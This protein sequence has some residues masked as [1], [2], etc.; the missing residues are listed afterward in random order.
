MKSSTQLINNAIVLIEDQLDAI[1]KKGAQNRNGIPKMA[2]FARDVL[3]ESTNSDMNVLNTMAT[4]VAREDSRR[5]A[6]LAGVNWDKANLPTD[7]RAELDG[8]V[9]GLGVA[10]W[11]QSVMDGICWSVRRALNN[12]DYDEKTAGEIDFASGDGMSQQDDGVDDIAPNVEQAYAMLRNLQ[13]WLVGNTS[14]ITVE[15]LCVFAVRKPQDDGSWVTTATADTF[16]DAMT[17]MEESI[18]DLQVETAE[19]LTH[20]AT[21]LDFTDTSTPVEKPSEIRQVP[22]AEVSPA[23][24]GGFF[25]KLLDRAS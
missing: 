16:A 17:L 4:I 8:L 25:K 19:R 7:L 5:S 9:A 3:V 15:T 1:A 14:G 2:R 6:I 20:E 13:E 22:V 24:H 10:G 12:R 11:L 21:T 18:A 23:A